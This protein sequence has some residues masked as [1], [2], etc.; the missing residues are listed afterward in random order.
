MLLATGMMSLLTVVLWP[1]V[2]RIVLLPTVV[3]FGLASLVLNAGLVM[4]AIEIVDGNAPSFLEALAASFLLSLALMILGP[5]FSFDDDA[6]QL[7]IVRRRP[8][9]SARRT[10]PTS[11][12]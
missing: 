6:R 7:R 2:I 3:T 8:E 5:A 1:I 9:R 4:L 11:P 10:G 12:E